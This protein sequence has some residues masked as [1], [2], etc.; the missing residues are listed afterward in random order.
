MSCD[1]GEIVCELGRIADRMSTFDA[2]AF[3]ST[4]LATLVGAGVASLISVLVYRHERKEQKRASLDAA[5]LDLVREISNLVAAHEDYITKKAHFDANIHMALRRSSTYGEPPT[6]PSE[7]DMLAATEAL[8]LLSDKTDWYVAEWTRQLIEGL[9]KLAYDDHVKSQ[10]IHAR[11]LLAA[12]RAGRKTSAEVTGLLNTL[13]ANLKSLELG[14]PSRVDELDDPFGGH[15][16]PKRL[17]K[18][19]WK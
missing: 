4:L 8:L 11:R 10:Y 15:T 19:K 18:L 9:S 6:A 12:W 3:L 2:N 13:R 7:F 1:P 16:V 5:T 17:R 14:H